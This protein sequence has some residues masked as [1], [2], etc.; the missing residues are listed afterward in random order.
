M[1]RFLSLFAGAA[2]FCAIS[3]PVLHQAAAIVA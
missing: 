3:A 1:T 2:V